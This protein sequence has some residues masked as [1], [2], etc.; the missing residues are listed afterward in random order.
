MSAGRGWRAQAYGASVRTSVAARSPDSPGK[1]GYACVRIVYFARFRVLTGCIVQTECCNAPTERRPLRAHPTTP[2]DSIAFR[3]HSLHAP[4]VSGHYSNHS[5]AFTG[6]L[7]AFPGGIPKQIGRSRR[8]PEAPR[9]LRLGNGV[10]QRAVIEAL[11]RTRRGGGPG[12]DF[13]IPSKQER[14]VS[15]PSVR[16]PGSRLVGRLAAGRRSRSRPAR[17][18][19]LVL[20][21][22]GG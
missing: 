11:V 3:F 21:A 8:P 18:C 2:R 16:C 9:P 5:P 7:D 12:R 17:C 6:V 19:V 20:V 1:Y 22:D 15:Q 14:D 4:T 10:V 13:C